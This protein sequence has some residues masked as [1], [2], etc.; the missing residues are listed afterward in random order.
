M[1]KHIIA[2]A[3]L[4]LVAGACSSDTTSGNGDPK[5]EIPRV[6]IDKCLTVQGN[7]APTA[8]KGVDFTTQLKEPGV[9]NVGSDND[10]PPFES[11]EGGKAVGF[12]VDLYTEVAT[13][14]G[15]SAKSTTTDFAALFTTS[16]PNGTFDIGVSAITIKEERKQSVDFTR[17]YFRADLSLA[18]NF[19]K[20]PEIKTVD[21]LAGLTIGVQ[22]GT[23]GADCAKALVE[24]GKAKEVREY[25]TAQPAFQDLVAGRVA[26]IVNDQ[27]ASEGFVKAS[28][29]LKVVQVLETAE[30][31]GFAIGK[32]KPDLRIKIDE[33]LTA[34]MNDG[35][36]AKIYKT[37]FGTE[38]PFTLP[39]A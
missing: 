39:I 29:D 24:Q 4:A 34:M 38:P 9:L 8:P 3:A 11:L 35:G 23:T 26:A 15:L 14:M 12:D 33:T 32:D 20:T 10:F 36:Y 16:I 18:V 5:V 30:Q 17:P 6:T 37:W 28:S 27:P 1:K 25:A 7:Q 13:R 21:D 22:E 31:Y 19:A 2:V